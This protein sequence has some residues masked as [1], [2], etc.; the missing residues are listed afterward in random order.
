MKVARFWQAADD[1]R[2]VPPRY[3]KWI[4]FWSIITEIYTQ[5]PLLGRS[6]ASNYR[7]TNV[8]FKTLHSNKFSLYV[9]ISVSFHTITSHLRQQLRSEVCHWHSMVPGL[10]C[11][12]D[13]EPLWTVHLTGACRSRDLGQ[14]PRYLLPPPT[15]PAQNSQLHQT[16]GTYQRGRQFGA[17]WT[18]SRRH[19][20][21]FKIQSKWELW[22]WF[23]QL[24]AIR[25]WCWGLP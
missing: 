11:G 24:A 4:S 3:I 2:V 19:L 22:T 17:L 25:G 13:L 15:H 6:F 10:P 12:M 16:L 5:Q 23:D 20:G 21:S 18:S 8:F 14:Y 9:T 1:I 7:T